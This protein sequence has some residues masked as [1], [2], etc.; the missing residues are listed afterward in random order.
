MKQHLTSTLSFE[1]D[2]DQSELD[3]RRSS[4]VRAKITG[5]D[6]NLRWTTDTARPIDVT[7]M[8]IDLG[9]LTLVQVDGSAEG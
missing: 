8:S 4:S 2:A 6:G 3:E 5:P 9:D 7:E 1:L